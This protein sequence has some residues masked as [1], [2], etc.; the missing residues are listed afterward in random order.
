MRYYKLTLIFIF[1]FFVYNSKAQSVQRPESYQ[2]SIDFSMQD[3]VVELVCNEGCGWNKFMFQLLE[4]DLMCVD[5]TGIYSCN[6]LTM[7]KNPKRKF[8]FSITQSN[9]EVKLKSA[10]GTN[11]DGLNFKSRPVGIVAILNTDGIKL[12]KSE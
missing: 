11:W 2:F 3:D 4:N 6:D 10:Q 9:N 8:L 12:S 5:N 7:D 1:V